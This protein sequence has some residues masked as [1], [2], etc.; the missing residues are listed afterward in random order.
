M[1]S[2]RLC[3]WM[4]TSRPS[5]HSANPDIAKYRTIALA[6]RQ[7]GLR[8]RFEGLKLHEDTFQEL[9]GESSWAWSEKLPRHA[10]ATKSLVEQLRWRSKRHSRGF[11]M[12]HTT[13]VV[14]GKQREHYE[15]TS[16]LT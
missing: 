12:R 5:N 3:L 7:L 2:D 6:N 13:W 1:I 14:G 16:T 4:Q 15:V 11:S 10:V 9:N 8:N